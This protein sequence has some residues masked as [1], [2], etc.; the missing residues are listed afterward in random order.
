MNFSDRKVF[1]ND[2]LSHHVYSME[3]RGY[4]L[5]E[6]FF[7]IE[8]CD[9]LKGYLQHEIDTYKPRE[10]SERSILDKYLMHDLI[11]KQI[12]FGRTLEDPRLDQLLSSVIDENWIMYAYTS[13]SLPPKGTNY[14]SRVHV[15][16]P[17][18]IPG[19][20]TNLGVIW[21]LDEF[22]EENGGTYVLPGSHHS[23]TL[24]TKDYFDKNSERLTCKKGSLIIFNARVW[25]RAGENV[26]NKFR[27][28]L[29][30]NICR[31]FMK[32]RCD[33]VRFIPE[34]IS[35][36]LNPLA[37]RIIGFDTRLPTSLDEFFLPEEK[38]LYKGNQE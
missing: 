4:N 32:Q 36:E 9:K 11:S 1:S 26:T 20:P 30:M 29:T 3:T 16:S 18:V 14:G 10:G 5:I 15:D 24:P 28:S 19:Y 27:H 35:N 8:E 6:D 2:L 34:S 38:R 21:A 7:S 23:K 31:P 22:T 37:R 12:E 13:S 17:R 33:W 25:H